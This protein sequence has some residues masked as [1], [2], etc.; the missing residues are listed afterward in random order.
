LR[1]RVPDT[2]KLRALG[3]APQRELR[4]GRAA[5]WKASASAK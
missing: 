2:R 4:E 5:C 3:F 1:R